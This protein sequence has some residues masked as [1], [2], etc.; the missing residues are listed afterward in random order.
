MTQHAGR[1]GS[2]CLLVWLAGSTLGF[3]ISASAVAQDHQHDH[4]APPRGT[5]PQVAF[6]PAT[7]QPVLRGIT[8]LDSNGRP[9]E[10]ESAVTA[11]GPVM[12]NFIFTSCTTI[13]PVMSAGFA[14]LE[15]R[16]RAEGRP[17]RLVSISVD[18]EFDTP[19]RLL[20]YARRH[21]AGPNWLFLTGSAVASEA[22][23]RA[24]GAY[25][26]GKENH[27]P[28]TYVR[29]EPGG[30]WERLDGLPSAGALLRA[31][32]AHSS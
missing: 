3:P 18:P 13:C 24:F 11:D 19:P 31:Y 29:R 2:F 9:V 28:V 26:G 22:A 4:S 16:L 6:R 8:L 27:A 14:Q 5:V 10:L 32:H 21:G 25:R 12:V 23:Q 17:V 1:A 7:P 20:A 15:S 30:S